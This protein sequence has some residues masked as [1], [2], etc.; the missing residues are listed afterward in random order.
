[1]MLENECVHITVRCAT[2]E[3]RTFYTGRFEDCLIVFYY[4]I[5]DPRLE[6]FE[7]DDITA[8]IAGLPPRDLYIGNLITLYKDSKLWQQ[9][10]NSKERIAGLNDIYKHKPTTIKT[11]YA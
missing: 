5:F 8:A 6:Y 10:L 1:M 11:I 4:L 9:A 2:E 7:A 3:S